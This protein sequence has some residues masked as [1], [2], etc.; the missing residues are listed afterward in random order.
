[1]PTLLEKYEVV[2]GR[3][4][5]LVQLP[6]FPLNAPLKF[7]LI[8]SPLAGGYIPSSRNFSGDSEASKAKRRSLVR[9][10]LSHTG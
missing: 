10:K 6:K 1:M 7:C 4:L 8:V 9:K 3:P 2:F 5:S